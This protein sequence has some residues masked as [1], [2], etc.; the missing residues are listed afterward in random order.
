MKIKISMTNAVQTIF[1][2]K[3]IEKC[4]TED[5][6][7][8]EKLNIYKKK[9][10]SEDFFENKW[11]SLRYRYTK[12]KLYAIG[13]E[14]MGETTARLVR[15]IYYWRENKL[16]KTA[17][18][19]VMP[20]FSES[21]M[22]GVYNEKA[23]EIFSRYLYIIDDSNLEFWIYVLRNHMKEVDMSDFGRYRFREAGRIP[24]Q[25]GIPLVELSSMQLIEAEKKFAKMNIGETF[26]CVHARE[27]N[28]KKSNYGEYYAKETMVCDWNIN[29]LEKACSY[30]RQ[31]GIQSVR[32]GKYECNTCMIPEIIDYSNQYY[33]ELMDFY[34]LQKC[35]FM[36]ASNSGLSMLAG[37]MGRPYIR[38]NSIGMSTGLES[39]AYLEMNMYIPK[40]FWNLEEERYLNLYEMIGI[41]DECHVSGSKYR[42]RN[43]QLI[44]NTE[45]EICEAVI[46]MNQ[47]MDDTWEETPQEVECMEKYWKIMDMWRRT[48]KYAKERKKFGMK[49]YTMNEDRISWNYLKKN[50][51]LIDVEIL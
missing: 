45:D 8:V 10:I 49:G 51:Y 33:D 41:V 47:R 37:Y 13:F 44:D 1:G 32:M 43:V 26:V 12:I 24:V 3:P 17:L 7:Y 22:G 9:L 5:N 28:E 15:M 50:L 39:S 2:K 14:S 19:V 11:R 4:Y 23:I 18:H 30:L 36:I 27:A 21:Y 35:K 42:E 16:D 40:K 6:L 34:L 38:V 48:H 31:Q 29:A 25:L 46:E 20:V